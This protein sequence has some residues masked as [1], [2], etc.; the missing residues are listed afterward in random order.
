MKALVLGAVIFVA[1][2]TLPATAQSPV[3]RARFEPTK[4]I[5]VG[6]PVRLV[7]S[8]Y[9]P[10]Y[11]TGSPEFPE[12]EI[13]NAIVVLPQ[14]RPENS[15]MQINGVSYAGI[16]ETYVVYPQQAGDFHL[17]TAKITVSYA[18]APPK[19]TTSQAPLPALSFH[20]DVPA[21]AKDLDYFLPTTN[22]TI[23]Q[24]WSRS[25]KGLRVG[26]SVERTITVTA[27]KMQAMLIPPLSLDTSN[28]IRVYPEEPTVRD[29]KTDR[30]DF[31]YGRRTQ[32]VKYLIQKEGDYTLPPIELKWW[33]ISTNHLATAS[34]PPVHFSA[35]A[36]LNYVS[37]LPPEPEPITAAPVQRMSLWKRYRSLIRVAAVGCTAAFLLT[38][39]GW[40]FV[41]RGYRSVKAWAERRK[42]SEATLFNKLLR[43]CL[44]NDAEQSYV[45]LLKWLAIQ[46]P[47]MSLQQAL[48]T[49]DNPALTSE[50]N[51]LG[52]ALFA[53]GDRGHP[54]NG[55]KFS[56]LL[57]QQR[58]IRRARLAH[59]PYLGDLNPKQ[60]A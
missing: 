16:T 41:P 38:W 14:D 42:H 30:G 53:K 58:K 29:Q 5:L 17:P 35:A 19:T 47:G 57:K 36:N 20:A 3:V 6:Q 18:V 55:R 44:H 49:T 45:W 37:E 28:G 60:P 34:L 39:I 27:A 1:I 10:N 8:I 56:T 11:F 48:E 24:S 26:D 25:L 40:R 2:L 59:H 7:V 43:A 12:F 46:Y 52:T 50:A 15:N 4:G 23:S 21:A 33:N 51:D 22:L 54:W 9:V 31:V 32:M 13:D